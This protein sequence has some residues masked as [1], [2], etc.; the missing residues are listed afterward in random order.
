MWLYV[1]RM[2][3]WEKAPYIAIAAA[4]YVTVTPKIAAVL[5]GAVVVDVAAVHDRTEEPKGAEA[6]Y[7]R[8]ALDVA[9]VLD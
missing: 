6:I 1:V 3:D 5:D 7:Q 9:A 8:V 4:P 2:N